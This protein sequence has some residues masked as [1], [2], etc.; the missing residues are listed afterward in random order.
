MTGPRIEIDANDILIA[1]VESFKSGLRSANVKPTSSVLGTVREEAKLSFIRTACGADGLQDPD[2]N[3]LHAQSVVARWG[4]VDSERRIRWVYTTDAQGQ[5]M[6]ENL[7]CILGWLFALGNVK[8]CHGLVYLEDTS[9]PA[10]PK[11]SPT[12]SALLEK[13]VNNQNIVIAT[14]GWDDDEL[15][16]NKLETRDLELKLQWTPVVLQG[17]SVLRLSSARTSR[18]ASSPE[19]IVNLITT[20][21]G[22]S[23]PHKTYRAPKRDEFLSD[24]RET[25][26][27]IP[28]MGLSGVGKSTFIN[29]AVRKDV[30]EV[31]HGGESQ[32]I[33]LQPFVLSHPTD[34]TRRIILVDT[35]GFDNSIEKKELKDCEISRRIAKWLARSYSDNMTLAGVVHLQGTGKDRTLKDV[36]DML[37][38]FGKTIRN[39]TTKDLAIVTT[40]RSKSG[41]LPVDKTQEHQQHLEAV[42]EAQVFY[43]DD[44]EASA[45]VIIRHIVDDATN[46]IRIQKAQDAT[47][48]DRDVWIRTWARR[49]LFSLFNPILATLSFVLHKGYSNPTLPVPS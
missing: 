41:H 32:T 39:D 22:Q 18:G 10:P 12:A 23:V 27:V 31:G 44:S 49:L 35:P 24:P 29:R 19:D 36:H 17:A 7:R 33:Y 5:K 42:D 20:K 38:V 28:V 8:K 11:L 14:V 48:R 26:M 1:Y 16:T 25:D 6:N 15:D 13:C 21:A 37:E 3:S 9:M 43:F 40:K 2:M 47:E 34:H 45:Q 4:S 30:T 46:L